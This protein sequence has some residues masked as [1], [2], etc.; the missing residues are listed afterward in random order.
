MRRRR[1]EQEKKRRPQRKKWT[2]WEL[3]AA[4]RK[5][6]WSWLKELGGAA[7]TKT[8]KQNEH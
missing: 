3:K 2:R 8:R 1:S 5:L 4:S 7:D 6:G